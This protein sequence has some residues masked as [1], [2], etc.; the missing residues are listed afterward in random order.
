MWRGR[1]TAQ[2]ERGSGRPLLN[3]GRSHDRNLVARDRKTHH[4]EAWKLCS[5][6]T[7]SVQHDGCDGE[8]RAMTNSEG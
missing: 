6:Y 4:F 8:F 7:G 1:H 3:M 2:R 5:R